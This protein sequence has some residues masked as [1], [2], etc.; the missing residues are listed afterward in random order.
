MDEIIES[1]QTDIK[2]LILNIRGTQVLLDSD[3]AMLYGYE[4]K[5]INLAA[6]RNRERFPA[7]FRFMLTQEE[8]D[9]VASLRLQIATLKRGEHR[10]YLPYVYTEQGIAMLSGILRNE[11]AVKVSIGIMEAFVEMRRFIS[12]YGKA[13][14]RISTVEYRLRE[15]DKKFDDSK[16]NSKTKTILT[17][18]FVKNIL[19]TNNK[20]GGVI[21][22]AKRES[23]RITKTA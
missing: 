10:K 16:N 23:I 21:G 7:H 12:T 1:K 5:N 4:T 14:E 19:F 2:S 22:Y 6:G 3:V 17:L 20:A 13:F 8:Y 11:T 9:Y 15:H 18:L